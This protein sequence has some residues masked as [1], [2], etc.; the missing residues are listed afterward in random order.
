MVLINK[1]RYERLESNEERLTQLLKETDAMYKAGF[2]EKID[3]SRVQ[4]NYN[5][6][7]AQRSQMKR[8]SELSQYMLKAQMGMSVDEAI[9][10]TGDIEKLSD[11]IMASSIDSTF[12][13]NDRIE[14][15][16]L[17]TGRNL[18][19]LDMRNYRVQ[20]LP[21]LYAIGT[22]GYNTQTNLSD[23]YFDFNDR[24][25][26]NGLVGLQLN[27][28]IFDGL[29]KKYSIQKT[30]IELEK[31]DNSKSQLE[32]NLKTEIKQK[33][34]RLANSLELMIVQK[35]NYE[36]AEEIYS[37]TKAKFQEGVGSNLELIEANNS[38]IDAQAIYYDALFDAA[39]AQIEL[40]KAL[41]H[42]NDITN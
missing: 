23:Q 2:A 35:E 29:R 14:F 22:F 6:I 20:Y 30:K 18:N 1:V 11:E 15:Q 19:E 27:I 37:T 33:K 36:L 32:N 40:H 3:V 34:D 21:N 42:F 38:L 5:N 41:G 10:L 31:I 13:F 25:L 39:V 17:E 8:L 28:P 12:E 24:W 4:V 7:K 16:L 26:N 9:M